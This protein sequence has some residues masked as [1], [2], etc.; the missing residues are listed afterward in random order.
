MVASQ[1]LYARESPTAPPCLQQESTMERILQEVTAVSRCLEGMDTKISELAAKTKSIRND[2]ASF[3]DGL[4]AVKR[5]LAA[6]EGHLS[7][8]PDRDQE[9]LYLRN[10]LTG[11][12]DRRR[13]DRAHFF[14]FLERADWTDV[15]D[16]LKGLLP[17]L[18]GLTIP[19]PLECQ[20]AHRMGPAHQ[21][22]TGRLCRIQQDCCVP[23]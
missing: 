8:I 14:G 23:L 10:K 3:H 11:L 9:L 7:T 21:D 13:R 6:V 22:S 20:R 17:S 2:Q 12:E 15:K 19:S 1:T 16:L 5:R 4:V 18:A